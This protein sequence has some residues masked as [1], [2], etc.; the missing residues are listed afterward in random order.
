MSRRYSLTPAA[1]AISTLG[2]VLEEGLVL[3]IAHRKRQSQ[4]PSTITRGRT[5]AAM[6]R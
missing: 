4:L 3:A 2:G 1:L 6:T 5:I